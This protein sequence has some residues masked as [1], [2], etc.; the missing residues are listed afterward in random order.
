MVLFQ[1]VKVNVNLLHYH[2]FDVS[3]LP[4]AACDVKIQINIKMMKKERQLKLCY[5]CPVCRSSG[6][7]YY[8][9]ERCYSS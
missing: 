2:Q 6:M 1:N 7:A 8:T 9:V 3:G 5:D 4:K